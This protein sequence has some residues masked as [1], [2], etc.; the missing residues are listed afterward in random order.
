MK[1]RHLL[2]LAAFSFWQFVGLHA[3]AGALDVTFNATDPGFGRGDGTNAPV[4]VLTPQPDGKVLVSGEFTTYNTMPARYLMRL[5]NDGTVDAAFSPGTGPNHWINTIRLQP[6]AK[7]L[8]GGRFSTYD[9]VARSCIARLNANGTLDASFN[10]GSGANSWLNDIALLPDGKILIVGWFTAYNGTDRKH[11]ARLNAD[12]SLDPSFNPGLGAD[13]KINTLALQP[14]G[15]ILI[16]GEFSSYD[17]VLRQGIARLNADGSLDTSFAPPSEG[18]NNFSISALLPLPDGKIL[19]GGNFNMYGGAKRNR[20]ARL[21]PDGALD[22]T[23]APLGANM[24]VLRLALQPDGKIL[25]SGYFSSFNGGGHKGIVRLHADGSTD[26]TFQP[27]TNES[28]SITG[29][30]LQPDNKILI[31]GR[32]SYINSIPRRGIARLNADGSLD[33]TFNPV[34][35]ANNI[36]LTITVQS[37]K[38]ILIGGCFES[39]NDAPTYAL[40]RLHADGSWDAAFNAG[41]SGISLGLLNAIVVQPDEKILIGGLFERYNNENRHNI[42][43][44]NPDGSVDVSF[45]PGMG[46]NRPIKALALQPDGKIL[47]AGEFTLYNGVPQKHIA[48]LHPDGKLDD[49]FNSGT[50][51]D[52]IVTA[53]ALQPDGKILIGGAFV[54]YNGLSRRRI[55]RLNADGSLDLSFNPGTG[56]NGVVNALVLQPNGKILIGGAFTSYNGAPRNRLARLNADGNLD[57]SFLPNPGPDQSVDALALQPDGRVIAAGTFTQYNNTPRSHI[58]RLNASGGLDHA[59]FTGSG[60][61]QAIHALALQPDGKVLVGGA[62][63]SIN[64]IGRNRIA[65][66]LGDISTGLLPCPETFPLR[67]YPNP[68][69]DL[70]WLDL[71]ADFAGQRVRI[72]VHNSAGQLVLEQQTDAT[73]NTPI[74]LRLREAGLAEGLYVV[75]AWSEKGSAIGRVRLA[76]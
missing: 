44:L 1:N 55:A 76:D 59:F 19:I 54:H 5:N 61:N 63:T 29:F 53:I 13:R 36:V 65:R 20:I 41:R 64:G 23:W 56:V 66:L 7:I 47:I 32:L 70:L 15:K 71:P 8:I 62:F 26:L 11:I 57:V 30:A 22:T 6:D 10:P 24:S 42:A 3:Q 37:D 67:A 27:T 34:T 52:S 12:G 51:P 49:T 16:G 4:Y 2:L 9:G 58:V 46:A 73:E 14:D 74:A 35:G 72:R 40:A 50:G 69:S 17:G 43:R 68:A 45:N 48:R 31:G 75:H 60:P 33:H 39:Y 28:L 21:H 38:K 25:V 18:S